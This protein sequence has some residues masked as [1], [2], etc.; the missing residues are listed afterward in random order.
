M[1]E[2]IAEK[3]ADKMA[4]AAL[5]DASQEEGEASGR[6]TRSGKRAQ[7]QEGAGPKRVRGGK[8]ARHT[9]DAVSEDATQPPEPK[10][11]PNMD[12]IAKKAQEELRKERRL[13]EAEAAAAAL[14]K[15]STEGS[16]GED[17]DHLMT[18]LDREMDAGGQSAPLDDGQL[19]T[20]EC[21]AGGSGTASG[22][23]APA[24]VP[25]PPKAPGK[26]APMEVISRR[27]IESEK[28]AAYAQE[29]LNAGVAAAEML[30]ELLKSGAIQLEHIVKATNRKGKPDRDPRNYV[31]ITLD[32]KDGK[33]I[34]V[35]SNLNDGV[36][37][38]NA[39]R[40]CY[41]L[42]RSDKLKDSKLSEFACSA[43][44]MPDAEAFKER[45]ER[46]RN[47]KHK[48]PKKAKKAAALIQAA[49]AALAALE[50]DSD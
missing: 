35:V 46:A 12:P 7:P 2:D 36:A 47:A 24:P 15:G 38:A 50:E 37:M 43:A 9:K 39:F 13:A 22:D 34:R 4:P 49:F 32:M 28:A 14:E 8:A 25:V 1:F 31:V 29:V 44:S 6:A 40:E 21:A 17:E 42:C 30:V 23:T 5:S 33:T 27:P 10:P 41:A 18:L 16:D 45:L 26:K 11:K 19:K 20:P 48:D 3:L